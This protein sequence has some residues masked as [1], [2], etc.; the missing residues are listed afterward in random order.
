MGVNILDC[1][2]EGL[3]IFWALLQQE[4]DCISKCGVLAQAVGSY[5]ENLLVCRLHFLLEFFSKRSLEL[6]L[7]LH[8]EFPEFVYDPLELT[9]LQRMDG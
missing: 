5:L 3:R 2:I 4:Q 8:L 6:L 7:G 1:G 9:Q